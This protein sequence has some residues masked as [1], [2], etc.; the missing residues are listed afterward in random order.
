MRE[1]SCAGFASLI[2]HIWG[3]SPHSNKSENTAPANPNVEQKCV[4]VCMCAFALVCVC[5]C[6]RVCVRVCVRACMC[7]CVC[8]RV[9]VHVRVHGHVQAHVHACACVRARV[10]AC[11][12]A[13]HVCGY[14]GVGALATSEQL[15]PNGYGMY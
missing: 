9:F 7:A 5:A 14:V 4:R 12:H 15:L 2:N 1:G 6:V 8:V 10:H 3:P 13:I 11:V